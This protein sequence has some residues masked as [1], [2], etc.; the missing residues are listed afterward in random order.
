MSKWIVAENGTE[1]VNADNVSKFRAFLNDDGFYNVF[2]F[3]PGILLGT[4]LF[5]TTDDEEALD[6]LEEIYSFVSKEL[7]ISPLFR[8]DEWV[9]RRRGNEAT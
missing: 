4:E 1:A 6:L 2:A 7:V 3:Q 5:K 9:A 8:V